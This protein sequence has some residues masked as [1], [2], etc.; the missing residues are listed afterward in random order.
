MSTT[1]WIE[2]YALPEARRKF[3]DNI[4]QKKGTQQNNK[5]HT[6]QQETEILST[7]QHINL[8]TKAM[9]PDK[10]DRIF[11]IASSRVVQSIQEECST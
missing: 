2:Q 5:Q 8:Y 9:I 11:T 3:F 10:N 4:A 6:S 1:Q 7:Q